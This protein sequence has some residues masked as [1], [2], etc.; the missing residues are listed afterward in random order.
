MV[1]YIVAYT[2]KYG[3]FTFVLGYWRTPKTYHWRIARVQ[4]AYTF[5]SYKKRR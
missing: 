3:Q 1:A 4:M 5:A 2:Q